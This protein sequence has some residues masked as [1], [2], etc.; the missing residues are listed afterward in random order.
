MDDFIRSNDIKH[1]DFIKI[2]VEGHEYSVLMGSLETIKQFKPIIFCEI[3]SLES[4]NKVFPLLN[5]VYDAIN[6]VDFKKVTTN[7]STTWNTHDILFKPKE[8]T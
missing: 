3:T 4:F 7:P 5:S 6:P 2:D 8:L 1:V